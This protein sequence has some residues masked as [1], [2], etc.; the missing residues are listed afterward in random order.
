MTVIIGF[1]FTKEKQYPDFC[2]NI[3]E[4]FALGYSANYISSA[5]YLMS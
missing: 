4:I 1:H 3:I 5:M 2:A